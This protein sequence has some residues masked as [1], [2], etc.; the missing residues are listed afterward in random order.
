MSLHRLG[1]VQKK[2]LL[3][4]LGGV[5]LGL[6]GSP[7][8]YS[9]TFQKIKREWG[10]I[11]NSNFKRS[12]GKLSQKKLITETEKADGSF[13]LA[14]TKEGRKEVSRLVLFENTID[15]KKPHEWDGKWRIVIFDIPEVDRVF[16]SIL[17][18]HLF[19]LKFYKLQQSVFIS[20]YPLE[21]QI[22]TLAKIY[23]AS[24]YVRV[25]TASK[26]DNEDKIKKH[27]KNKLA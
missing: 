10:N 3:V 2:I 11:K 16:R 12:V 27:F 23:R 21:K 17:R 24:S 1:P 4:L 14:L 18:Q 25:V 22:I 5:A 9:Y 13:E 6:A 7:R 20:P 26:I 19:A 8:Q 15:F